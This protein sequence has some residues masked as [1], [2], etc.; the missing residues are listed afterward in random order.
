MTVCGGSDDLEAQLDD[1]AREGYLFAADGATSTLIRAGLRPRVIVTDLDGDVDD[2][3]RANV[4]GSVVFVH[5]HGDNMDA[6]RE[7]VPRFRGDLV[8]TCQCPPVE[9]VVNFGGFTDGDR[10]ACVASA[11]GAHA[12]R[13]LGFDFE[14]PS[15]KPGRLPEV[16]AKKLAWAKHILS[17]L[18]EEGVRLENLPR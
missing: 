5:A 2:Q 14:H 7:H 6:V 12:V 4:E 3:V 13:L 17:M 15:E 10:A 8:C 18:A 1:E 9:G 11:L 16:K